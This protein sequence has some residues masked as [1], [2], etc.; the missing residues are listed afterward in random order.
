MIFGRH[1]FKKYISRDATRIH[2]VIEQLFFAYLL[3]LNSEYV[4]NYSELFKN[5]TNRIVVLKY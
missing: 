4:Q 2:H 1:L 3:T 5:H